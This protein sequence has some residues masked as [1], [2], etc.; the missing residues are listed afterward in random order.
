MVTQNLNSTRKSNKRIIRTFTGRT[1]NSLKNLADLR[2]ILSTAL[3]LIYQSLKLKYEEIYK[4]VLN[5]YVNG[6]K[7]RDDTKYL[8]RHIN[9]GAIEENDKEEKDQ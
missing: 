7:I 5:N 6:S 1:R 2:G 3:S 8:N 4:E 9:N